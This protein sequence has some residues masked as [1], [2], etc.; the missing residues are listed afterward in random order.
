MCL[1]TIDNYVNC[2]Q[3]HV[4][5]DETVRPERVRQTELTLNNH[6]RIWTKMCKIGEH[7]KHQW[8]INRALISNYATIPPLMG[9][10]KDHK[11]CINKDPVLGPKLRPLCPANLAPSAPLANLMATICKGLAD[12]IQ[13]EVRT[14]VIITEEMMFSIGQAN[15]RVR[16]RLDKTRPTWERNTSN[17]KIL[18]F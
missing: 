8:R 12:E 3:E 6:S 5:K 1:D 17:R 9:L 11:E 7:N 18:Y 13:N 16:E 10:R 15:Q 4:R 2:M 14:E